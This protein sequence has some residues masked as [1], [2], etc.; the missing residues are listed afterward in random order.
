MKK[1]LVA[2]KNRY[3]W[4]II[5]DIALSENKNLIEASSVIEI[6]NVNIFTS[7]PVSYEITDIEIFAICD[8]LN[9]VNP[10]N[11]CKIM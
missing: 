3:Y 8:D 1:E 10:G 9:T 2:V 5:L 6:L 11:A 7:N 4:D